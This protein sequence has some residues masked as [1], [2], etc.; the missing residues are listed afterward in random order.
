MFLVATASLAQAQ[1]NAS[2]WNGSAST[3]WSN[4][5]NW[6][7]PTT[8][9]FTDANGTQWGG[10]ILNNG[11]TATI[12]SGDNEDYSISGYAIIGARIPV[13]VPPAGLRREWICHHE[14]RHF[15]GD[16]WHPTGNGSPNLPQEILGLDSGSGIFTQTGGLN[17]PYN[18]IP[19]NT[20]ELMPGSFTSL[21]LGYSN[22]G[23]GQYNLSG[24]SLDVNAIYVGGNVNCQNGMLPET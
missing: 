13:S 17:C 15:H 21:Q 4:T 14:R 12:A 20:T 19:P 11:G 6:T 8:Q 23:Y 18:I 1:T 3:V 2:Y 24:G 22:G 9:T 5:A 7:L 10:S 16:R